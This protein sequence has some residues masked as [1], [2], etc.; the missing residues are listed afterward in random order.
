[1]PYPHYK[2]DDFLVYVNFILPFMM[3]AAY[4]LSVGLF[5]K[6]IAHY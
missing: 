2:V 5:T 3:T 4:L 6:V 1:M